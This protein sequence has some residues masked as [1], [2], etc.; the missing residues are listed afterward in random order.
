MGVN[1]GCGMSPLLPEALGG[2]WAVADD[3]QL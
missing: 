3:L 1:V 2:V